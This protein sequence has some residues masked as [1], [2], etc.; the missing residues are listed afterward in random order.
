MTAP[1]TPWAIQLFRKSIL[2][3]EKYRQILGLLGSVEGKTCLDIGGDNGVIS[4]LLRQRGGTWHSADL[5]QD[6]VEAIRTLVHTDV[7]CIDGERMPFGDQAFDV[8]VV[9]DFLE[10]IHTDWAFVRELA[11][12][13]KSEG[14]LIVNVPHLKRHSLLNRVRRVIGLTDEWHGHVRPG[15]NVRGLTDLLGDRFTIE[16]YRTYSR[17]FSEGVD[18]ILNATYE[19]LR[20]VRRRTRPSSAKG[21]VVT[22]ADW[23]KHRSEMKL[24][25]L[26]YPF[27]WLLTRLDGL[28]FMQPGYKLI[29]KARLR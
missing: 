13:L 11:R 5:E 2:K 14:V 18:T 17:A 27:L 20:R 23:S 29:L 19:F 12:I 22:Q 16:H 7:H 3:Q 26:I 1:D 6:T 24:L 10:H 21:P 28:L 25:T 15:Y 9:V 8:V 4:Y